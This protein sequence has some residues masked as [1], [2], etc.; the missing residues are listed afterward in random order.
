MS[1]Q[2]FTNAKVVSPDS[3]FD[4]TVVVKDGLIADVAPGRSRATGSIDLEGDYLLP[5]LVEIH[6]DNLERNIAP[7]PR[8]RWPML[9]AALAH[10]S[11]IVSAGITTV[12]DALAVGTTREDN[13]LRLEI[14]SDSIET[15]A[16]AKR[17]GLLKADHLVHLRCEVTFPGV[18]E[19][20][21]R[22]ED[23]PLVAL[24]SLM[25][26]TPGQRQFATLESFKN[27]YREW[28]G[29]DDG[30]LEALVLERQTDHA[31]HAARNRRRLSERSLA[32]RHHLASHDDATHAHIE[33]AVSLGV[34]IA[35]FP[36]TVE[37]AEAARAAGLKTVAGA[38]NVVRG[39]S[40]SG[41]ISASE[42][43]RLGLLDGLSS[44]YMPV[45]LLHAAFVLNQRLGVDLAQAVSIVSANPADMVG[46]TD[47]GRI[48][49]GLRADL[50]RAAVYK[51][52]PHARQVWCAGV[53]IG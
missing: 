32:R 53:R 1:E 4:G 38:P 45:S 19:L 52:Q 47:R 51:D 15:I 34:T 8:V 50:V 46:L 42:L 5:G 33:E 12:F 7:R 3:V 40:H 21:E 36:T 27:Y 49:P 17:H 30:Q 25:D 41:N 10:D 2:I 23:E 28:R 31:E 37:A 43:A 20:F 11:Q 24:V 44:D 13:P 39:A 6:T 22:F 48:A 16:E 18:I 14:L 35:E 9:S 29:Y 26:H